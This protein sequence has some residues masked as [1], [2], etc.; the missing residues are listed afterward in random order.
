MNKNQNALII[1]AK[2]PEPGTV[3]TRLG[4]TIGNTK[5]ASIYSVLAKFLVNKL[6]E[7]ED[8][9]TY[10]FFSPENKKKQV[11][12]WINKKESDFFA[13][14]GNSLGEKMSNAFNK[15]FG[16][17]HKNLIIIGTDCIGIEKEEIKK[18]FD[19]LEENKNQII[20]GPSNDGGYY[21]LGMNSFY[22]FLFNEIE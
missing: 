20:L 6:A 18:G 1:F 8:Y 5:S 13:Q 11:I 4:K 9:N 19:L 14:H 22:D 15:C 3:K 17:Q 7:S 12:K 16:L 2:Y 21:L 10:V